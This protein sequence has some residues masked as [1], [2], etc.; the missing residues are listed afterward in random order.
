MPPPL[1]S[2]VGLAH[3]ESRGGKAS[4][5]RS[6]EPGELLHRS[7]Q[8]AMMEILQLGS[9]NRRF[10]S[11]LHHS[12]IL[13]TLGC[14]KPSSC[15]S[16]LL[17][18]LC[19]EHRESWGRLSPHTI[20][21][22]LQSQTPEGWCRKEQDVPQKPCHW[23]SVCKQAQ[24]DTSAPREICLIQQIHQTAPRARFLAEEKGNVPFL[25]CPRGEMEMSHSLPTSWTRLIAA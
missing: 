25:P 11:W 15:F 13:Q 16:P 6:W 10:L 1:E 8:P 23:N 3:R 24:G 18:L 19:H 5:C 17:C 21:S 22:S 12:W 20:I 9:F 7:L 2:G 14:F 4:E